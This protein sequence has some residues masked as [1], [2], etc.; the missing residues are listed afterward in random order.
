MV[1]AV[2]LPV[3]ETR[4]NLLVSYRDTHLSQKGRDKDEFELWFFSCLGFLNP[5]QHC[6]LH[7]TLGS[8]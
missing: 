1:A 3:G 5:S 2:I 7:G 8:P 6:D 4:G